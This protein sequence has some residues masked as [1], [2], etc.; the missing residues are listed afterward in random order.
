MMKRMT[1]S[2]L[3]LAFIVGCSIP[4][5]AAQKAATASKEKPLWEIITDSFKD[6][7]VREQDK[8]KGCKKVNVFQ[9]ISDGIK[10]GSNSAKNKSLRSN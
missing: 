7:K 9:N 8:I 4:A 2:L 6:F 5:V 3:V 10:G 1:T